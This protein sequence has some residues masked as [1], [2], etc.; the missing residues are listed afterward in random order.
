[1]LHSNWAS[2]VNRNCWKKLKLYVGNNSNKLNS[3]K[4]NKQIISQR[5]YTFG[6]TLLPQLP[7]KGFFVAIQ[8]EWDSKERVRAKKSSCN[9]NTSSLCP[10]PNTYIN[11][12]ESYLAYF[13]T[14]IFQIK[15]F[16]IEKDTVHY[17]Y[18]IIV[19]APIRS[20]S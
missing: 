20:R 5:R 2:V 12:P 16:L 13:K 10:L 17:Y 8:L 6:F 14:N 11:I 1:M 9:I 15:I 3:L 19:N 4:S 7:S 18:K